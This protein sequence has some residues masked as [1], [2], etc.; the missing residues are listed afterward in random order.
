MGK[1]MGVIPWDGMTEKGERRGWTI[2]V[3]GE[4]DDARVKL[5]GCDLSP[6]PQSPKTAS[7]RQWW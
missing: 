3:E 5:E 7:M 1:E 6:L 2:M 4:V